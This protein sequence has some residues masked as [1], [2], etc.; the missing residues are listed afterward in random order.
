M[1]AGVVVTVAA[2]WALCHYVLFA[3]VALSYRLTAEVVT[4]GQTY[5]GSAVVE[6]QWTQTLFNPLGLEDNWTER[7]KGEAVVVDMA[8]HG[9]VLVTLA[10]YTRQQPKLLP[11]MVFGTEE[12]TRTFRGYLRALARDRHVKPVKPDDLPVVIWLKNRLD[13]SSA[14]CIEPNG[15]APATDAAPSFPRVQMQMV[16]EPPTEQVYAALPWLEPILRADP[17]G[18]GSLTF[19][20]LSRRYPE[21]LCYF[22]PR[23]LKRS[24]S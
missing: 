20:D 11:Q 22:S 2:T 12:G 4:D 17:Y 16:D 19:I 15:T 5:T 23:D 9:V 18:R 10:G 7:E 21:R 1:S 8:Q 14:V 3:D 13:P 24:T 6:T